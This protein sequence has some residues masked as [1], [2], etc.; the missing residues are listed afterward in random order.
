MDVVFIDKK[1]E[2]AERTILRLDVT[3]KSLGTCTICQIINPTPTFRSHTDFQDGTIT[4]I[5]EIKE[6]AA[7]HSE[8]YDASIFTGKKEYKLGE[9]EPETEEEDEEDD[10]L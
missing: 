8:D 5:G 10:D 6:W 1:S 9:Y 3:N 4:S 2:Q 7:E